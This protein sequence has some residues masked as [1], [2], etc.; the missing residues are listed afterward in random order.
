MLDLFHIPEVIIG[1]GVLF[2]IIID[3]YLQKH[4]YISYLL[5]QLLLIVAGYFTIIG[6]LYPSYDAYELSNFT[7]IL[8]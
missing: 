8:P 4:K 5:V 2:I 3:L 7:R 6:G 1:I